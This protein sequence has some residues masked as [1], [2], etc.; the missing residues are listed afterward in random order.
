R[1][2]TLDMQLRFLKASGE[3]DDSVDHLVVWKSSDES[4]ATVDQNG[5]V[6]ALSSGDTRIT[7][8][9][10]GMVA[11]CR[12]KVEVFIKQLTLDREEIYLLKED[13]A[14]RIQLNWTIDPVDAD[15]KRI[16]FT[17][18]NEQVATVDE[19]GIVSLTGGY[20]SVTIT[21]T[22][23]SGAEDSFTI[24]VVTHLP[25]PE[26]TVAPT[27]EPY[28]FSSMLDENGEIGFAD[29]DEDDGFDFADA[30]F[31]FADEDDETD[32]FA[33]S[34]ITESAEEQYV[35][36]GMYPW[37]RALANTPEPTAAPQANAGSKP[38]WEA[39]SG[40][41]ATAA[42]E[43]AIESSADTGASEGLYPWERS[44]AIVPPT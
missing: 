13:T 16:T 42:P 36:T 34:G 7:A 4:V 12:L 10:D 6:T 9:S 18:D 5:R 20:G 22:A 41:E 35:S 39:A 44:G 37:E 14:K 1:G 17:S 32:G 28:S 15:D 11:T 31:S 3:V 26:P 27:P 43:P 8:T 21:A 38:A 24:H 30:D 23:A 40:S 29:E 19:A 33:G 25:T 2:D